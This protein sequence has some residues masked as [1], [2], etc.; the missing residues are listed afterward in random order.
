MND[1]IKVGVSSC[2]MGNEVRYDGGHQLDK[3]IRDTLGNWFEYAPVCP[4]VECGLPIPREAMRL[5]GDPADPRLITRKTGRDITSQMKNWAEKK[6]EELADMDLCGFIFKS[7]SPSSGMTRVKVYNE[8]GFPAGHASGIFAGLFMERF[9]LTPVEDDGRLHDPKLR[10]M[11]I[12]RIFVYKRWRE[13]M[14]DG[15]SMG[16]LVNFHTRHKLLL[17]A[18]SP[19][20]YRLLGRMV[21]DGKSRGLEELR[22]DYLATLHKALSLKTTAKKNVNVM[23][24]I[25][26]YFKKVLTPDEKRELLDVI[27]GYAKGETPL[28]VP[29]TLLK[30]YVRKYDQPYLKDQYYL[31]P[32]PG[33]LG[34][35]NHV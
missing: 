34:L 4:E 21:G 6:L 20:L 22:D 23:N 15:F 18:H 28:V 19:D 8:K 29:L 17:M 10:E 27:E 2:L 1:K 35:R 14:K 5:V 7:R 16:R 33:E 3:Y 9:P 25:M 12:E 24:H 13:A 31:N 11:F 30:H 26:G 32:H